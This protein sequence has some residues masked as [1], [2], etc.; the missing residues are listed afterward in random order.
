VTANLPPTGD[1]PEHYSH[2]SDCDCEPCLTTL[3][4]GYRALAKLR[5]RGNLYVVPG[6]LMATR[7]QYAVRRR[8][9]DT[10]W[11]RSAERWLAREGV[12]PPPRCAMSREDA[13]SLLEAV[14]SHGHQDAEIVALY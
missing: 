13:E 14:R 6:P 2:P 1:Y 9:N 11:V 8:S 3:D 5:S 10:F 7:A 12:S 4:R